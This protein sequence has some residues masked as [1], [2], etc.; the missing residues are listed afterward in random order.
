MT[1]GQ[2]PFLRRHGTMLLPEP[3]A[4]APWAPDMLHGRL[5]TA[6]AARAMSRSLQIP[7]ST[8]RVFWWICSEPRPWTPPP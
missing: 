3:V 2:R 6:L 8:V 5:I 1:D 4:V 7:S